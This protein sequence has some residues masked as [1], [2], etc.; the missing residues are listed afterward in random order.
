MT[1]VLLTLHGRAKKPTIDEVMEELGLSPEEIDRD[2]G[3][4][5]IDPVAGDYSIL[6]AEEA[7]K[8]VSPAHADVSGPY[9]NPE[10]ETFGPPEP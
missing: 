8:R 9:A 5:M 6:V 4:Q 1:K 7:A 3:V 10:I 2:H